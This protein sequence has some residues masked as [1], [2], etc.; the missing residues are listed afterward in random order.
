ME[1]GLECAILGILASESYQREKDWLEYG[2]NVFHQRKDNQSRPSSFWTSKDIDEYIEK[3]NLN[4]PALYKK[5]YSRNGCMFCGFG[6]QLENS[7]CNRFQLLK[8][9]HPVQYKYLIENFGELLKEFDI[10]FL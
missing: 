3:Y 9:T 6:V 8:T 4:I 7:G 2:C 5:G 1:L 10:A